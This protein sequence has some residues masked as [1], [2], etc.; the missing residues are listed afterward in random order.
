MTIPPGYTRDTKIRKGLVIGGAV[1]FGA[2]WL[3]TAAVGAAWMDYE[4]REEESRSALSVTDSYEP[5]DVGVLIIPVAGPFIAIGTLNASAGGGTLLAIDGLAQA[6]GLAMLIV[7][8]AAKKDVL[9]R[10]GDVEM[11]VTPAIGQGRTGLGLQG[12]F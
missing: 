4:I 2:V 9:I 11:T 8:L 6:G 1:T 7:G 10:T 3:L 12:S 5:A